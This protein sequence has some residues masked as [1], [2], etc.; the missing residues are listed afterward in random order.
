MPYDYRGNPPIASGPPATEEP[1]NLSEYL[2]ILVDGR[3]PADRHRRGLTSRRI[4][5]YVPALVLSRWTLHSVTA[6]FFAQGGAE[7]VDLTFRTPGMIS[8]W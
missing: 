5:I 1:N 7:Q 8:S 6:E 2:Y 3:D 4:P